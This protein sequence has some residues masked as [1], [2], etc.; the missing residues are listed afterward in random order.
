MATSHGKRLRIDVVNE[1][2]RLRYLDRN[3]LREMG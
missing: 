3:D 1:A 2:I